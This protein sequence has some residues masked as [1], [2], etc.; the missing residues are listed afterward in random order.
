LH[1]GAEVLLA[2]VDLVDWSLTPKI[3]RAIASRVHIDAVMPVAVFGAPLPAAGWDEFHSDTDIP[4][5]IDAAAALGTQSIPTRGLAAFSLH[6]TKPFGI[7]EGGLLVG[8]DSDLIRKGRQYSNFGLI[9]RISCDE[10]TNAKMSEY[11]AAV[12]LAQLDR[13]S[14]VKRKR[15]DLLG[16]YICQLQPLLGNVSL[17][18]AVA[19]AVVSLL[20]VLLGDPVAEAVMAEGK[21]HGIAMHRTYL[22]PLYDH[23]F[24]ASL[25]LV[26]TEGVILSGDAQAVEKRAYMVNCERLQRRLLGVPFH[27]HMREEDVATVV[28]QLKAALGSFS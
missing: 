22:P 19:D 15:R 21:C 25:N 9:D 27:A 17:H 12:A 13:W 2:D 24:L 5:V 4:F 20:M 10:G 1:T 6:A 3:A 7:G 23:P 8:R 16:W 28:S 26:N 11:H 18:P 14:E